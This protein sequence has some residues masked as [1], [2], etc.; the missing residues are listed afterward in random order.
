MNNVLKA[1]QTLLTDNISPTLGVKRVEV[2][3][4]ESEYRIMLKRDIPFIAI[5]PNGSPRE[6][7]STWANCVKNNYSI[8]FHI[9]GGLK[10]PIEDWIRNGSHNQKATLPEIAD[11]VRRILG[12]NKK[13]GGAVCGLYEQW[14]VMDRVGEAGNQII[15]I[16]AS[17]FDDTVPFTGLIN[18]QNDLIPQEV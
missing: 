12:T 15:H 3:P 7:K 8:I 1:L 16:E 5:I 17:W 4:N 2:V 18:N 13:L 9:V 6:D 11:E 10:N 14:T